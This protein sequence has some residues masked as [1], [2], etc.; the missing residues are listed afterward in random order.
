MIP[1]QA[2]TI[3][4]TKYLITVNPGDEQTVDVKIK[5]EELVDH[6]FKILVGGLQQNSQG[7]L[8]FKQ[9]TVLAEDWV[10]PAKDKIF[11]RAGATASASFLLKIPKDL[12]SGSYFL[13]LAVETADNV[14]VNINALNGRLFSILILRV[15]GEVREILDIEK[16]T[17][18][19][20]WTWDKEW[21]LV[22]GIKNVG[23]IDIPIQ[24]EIKILSEAEQGKV[25]E[26]KMGDNLLVGAVRDLKKIISTD[27][28]WPGR[29]Q[30]QMKIIYGRTGQTAIS[31][32]N[33][34]YFPKW[35][36]VVGVM[37]LL[38]I[39]TVYYLRRKNVH[40]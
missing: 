30:V 13:G 23:N 26:W 38:G 40:E 22:L 8:V 25:I 39:L 37:I 24:G 10:K 35:S 29:Y 27:F 4:P 34:W 7:V 12:P 18:E 1:V 5:N 31:L 9:S 6:N 19:N 28:F 32:A 36:V 17:G 15:A 11:L 16:W 20:R 14:D 3:S 21:P 33:I 2:F